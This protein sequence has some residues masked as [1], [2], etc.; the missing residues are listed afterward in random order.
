MKYLYVLNTYLCLAYKVYW[1]NNQYANR[2]IRELKLTLELKENSLSKDLIKRI[3]YYTSQCYIAA[4]W[5][6]ALRGKGLS[7]EEKTSIISLGAITPILDDLTDTFNLTS[8][9]ILNF[10]EK[11]NGKVQNEFLIANYLYNK[12][13]DIHNEYFEEIFKKVLLSQDASIQQLEERRLNKNKL[14]EITR[15]KGAMSILLYRII[16]SNSLMPR[17]QDALMTLGYATQLINDMFDINKDHKNELQTLYT[18]SRDL[19]ENYNE[20]LQ[21]INKIV[22]QYL[23]LDFE[24][25][26]IKKCLMQIST[27]LGRGMV[28]INQ[29]L[30]LQNKSKGK[31]EIEKFT[32]KQL[33]CDM[34]KPSNIIRSAIYSIRFYNQISC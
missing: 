19:N 18:N 1:L 7:K 22:S 5:A 11:E 23:S 10:L 17:E 24:K 21:I 33:I 6:C 9:E 15:N 16:L 8:R 3:K 31:F 27:I 2:L 25:K 4:S 26:N 12:L 30:L 28:C 29:L 34:E 20:Y 32:E 14:K 13:K